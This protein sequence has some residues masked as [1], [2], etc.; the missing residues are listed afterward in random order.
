MQ[1]R[2]TLISRLIMC[3]SDSF[4]FIFETPHFNIRNIGKKTLSKHIKEKTDPENSTCYCE[5]F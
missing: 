2:K 5:T 4:G 1:V 3:Y